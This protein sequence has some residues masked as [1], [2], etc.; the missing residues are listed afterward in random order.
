LDVCFR[1]NWKLA[2]QR[3]TETGSLLEYAYHIQLSQDV[4]VLGEW[5]GYPKCFSRTR[6]VNAS[7]DEILLSYIIQHGF[8]QVDPP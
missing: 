8:P 5:W 7:D 3:L 1:H 6:I 2:T 4:H